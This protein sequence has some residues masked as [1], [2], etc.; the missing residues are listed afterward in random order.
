MNYAF[1]YDQVAKMVEHD[2][3]PGE[4]RVELLEGNLVEMPAE[5]PIHVGVSDRIETMMRA[6]YP[7]DT[8]R[9]GRSL[10]VNAINAPE[11]DIAIVRGPASRYYEQHPTG[12]D[13]ILVI[14]LAVTSLKRDREKAARYARGGVPVYWIVDV[15][16][17]QLEVH[18]EPHTLSQRYVTTMKLTQHEKIAL[19]DIEPLTHVLVKDLFI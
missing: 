7:N 4:A 3:L 13:A 10:I 19:P 16:K 18:F 2:I 9:V 14:E 15:S 12:M 11:P 1:T 8:V 17:R 6:L 5:G